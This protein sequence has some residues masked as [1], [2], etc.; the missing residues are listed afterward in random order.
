MTPL[1]VMDAGAGL[2]ERDASED[3]V[4]PAATLVVSK[5]STTPEDTRGAT[6]TGERLRRPVDAARGD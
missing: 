4:V 6:V 3:Q 5:G 1:P 2:L